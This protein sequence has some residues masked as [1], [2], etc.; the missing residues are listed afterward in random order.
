MLWKLSIMKWH[1]IQASS[2]IVCPQCCVHIYKALWANVLGITDICPECCVRMFILYETGFPL[3]V[4][5]P[6]FINIL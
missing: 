3:C 4:S 6:F 1:K 5:S 2:L